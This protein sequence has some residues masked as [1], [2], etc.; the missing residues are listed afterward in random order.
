MRSGWILPAQQSVISIWTYEYVGD[1]WEDVENNAEG[2]IRYLDPIK[3]AYSCVYDQRQ[4][5]Y[6]VGEIS[7]DPCFD[8]DMEKVCVPGIHFCWLRATA[9]EYHGMYNLIESSMPEEPC[10]S[11]SSNNNNSNNSGSDNHTDNN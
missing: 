6:T 9:L 1:Y 4:I 8:P 3:T 5:E 10:Q 7:T 2:N 11:D